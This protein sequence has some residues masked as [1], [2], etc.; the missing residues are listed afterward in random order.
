MLSWTEIDAVLRVE[1]GDDSTC[2]T[3]WCVRAALGK[4]CVCLGVVPPD[5]GANADVAD[6]SGLFDEQD[7]LCGDV[8]HF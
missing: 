2:L 6:T 4:V 7:G 8:A 5:S 3:L 1:G